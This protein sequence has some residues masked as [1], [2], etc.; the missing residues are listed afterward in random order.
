MYIVLEE[1]PK[2]CFD[3]KFRTK[4]NVWEKFLKLPFNDYGI[5]QEDLRYLK[6]TVF[7]VC[8]LR[9]IPLLIQKLYVKW[10]MKQCRHLCLFCKF[11]KQCELCTVKGRKHN[12]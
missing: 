11:K 9:P 4:C 10:H 3:C 8:R 7:S 1:L 12:G 2:N 5:E 6:P